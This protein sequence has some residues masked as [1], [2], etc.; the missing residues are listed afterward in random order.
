[1]SDAKL[2]LIRMT[3]SLYTAL[4]FLAGFT[5]I[6]AM[7]DLIALWLGPAYLYMVMGIQA[8]V[9]AAILE[10]SGAIKVAALISQGKA[11]ALTLR[12]TPLAIII[13]FAMVVLIQLHPTWETIVILSMIFGILSGGVIVEW[14]FSKYMPSN[15]RN[16]INMD[17][18]RLLGSFIMFGI[19]IV[20]SNQDLS[21]SGVIFSVLIRS[22]LALIIGVAIVHM[23]II[24]L[25]DVLSCSR[26]LIT[27]ARH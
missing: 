22:A 11:K 17:A 14:V 27:M 1:M 23:F 25:Q 26:Q 15:V 21:H 3:N 13:F 19:S 18:G 10:L 5:L 16:V 4:M 2:K 8:I 20:I 24:K 6:A 12:D 7:P 9:F